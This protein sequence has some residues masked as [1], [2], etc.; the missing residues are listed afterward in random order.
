MPDKPLQHKNFVQVRDAVTREVLQKWSS[1]RHDTAQRIEWATGEFE[2]RQ[3]VVELVDGD[4][5]GA[6]AWLA[7]GRFSVEAL[8][9][10]RRAQDRRNGAELAATFQLGQFRDVIGEAALRALTDPARVSALASAL[11]QMTPE[12]DSR[13]HALAETTSIIG[14]SVAQRRDSVQALIAENRKAAPELLSKAMLT[15]STAEQRRIAEVLVSDSPGARLLVELAA[16]GRASA[17][18]LKHPQIEPK[19]LAAADEDLKK[20]IETLTSRLPDES[21]ELIELIASRRQNHVSAP[22]DRELGAKLFTKSCAACHQIA[23]KGKKVGPNLDGIGNRGLDRLVEDILAPNRN[24]DVAFRS[25]TIVTDQ[26]RVLNGLIK[27]TE[28][29]RLVLVD[30]KGEEISVATD[31]IEQRVL[32]ILS[33]MPANFGESLTEEQFRQLLAYLLAL[34]GS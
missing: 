31:S 11:S 14:Q 13:L 4:P 1:R 12:A 24:V 32:S 17:R 25:S 26:G 10:S 7:V 8:N 23:G 21:Q 20:K 30:S 22:G 18:L 19:L 34:R 28:G 16:V 15:A 3:V 33:P 2:G 29:A 9:P 6:Y 27:R 5:G